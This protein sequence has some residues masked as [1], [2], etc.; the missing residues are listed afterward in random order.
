M[1]EKATYWVWIPLRII[2]WNKIFAKFRETILL[3]QTEG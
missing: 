3:P 1:E 2:N